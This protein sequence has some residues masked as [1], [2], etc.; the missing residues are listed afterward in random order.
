M[1]IA[2]VLLLVA[3]ATPHAAATHSETRSYVTAEGLAY[4]ALATVVDCGSVAIGG[5]CFAVQAGESRVALQITDASGLP[6]AGNMQV[7][8][9]SGATILS[10]IFCA[11]T[12]AD[13]PAGA[14]HVHVA[15]YDT[16]LGIPACSLN[17][18][19]T[20]GTITAWFG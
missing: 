17:A 18:G 1:R 12:E 4:I 6:T 3:L 2:L 16:A 9:A 8:D 15:L 14:T 7:T 11:T 13:L 20:T 19:G 10:T 5:T